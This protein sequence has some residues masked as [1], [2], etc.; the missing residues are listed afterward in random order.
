M[1][2]FYGS[3]RITIVFSKIVVKIAKIKIRI[4]IKIVMRE[5]KRGVFLRNLFRYNHRMRGTMRISLFGG[6]MENWNEYSFYKET[7][8]SFLVPTYLTF[9]LFNIQKRGKS[10][11]MKDEVM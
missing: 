11:E 4:A 1:K 5:V 10:F 6:I 2:I 7:H 9:F 8:S 3:K